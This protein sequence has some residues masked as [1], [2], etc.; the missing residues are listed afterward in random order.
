M[1]AAL[2]GGLTFVATAGFAM[3]F[4][5]NWAAVTGHA[6]SLFVSTV[7]PDQ[8]LLLVQLFI[9]VA[10]LSALTLAAEVAERMRAQRALQVSEAARLEADLE[11]LHTTATE[12]RRIAS[13]VHDIVGHAL[14]VVLLQAGGAR[15]IV[16]DHPQRA[17]EL[18][19]SIESTGRD[20][21]RDL[22][23]ALG[24][25]DGS[26]DAALGRGLADLEE[27]VGSVRDAGVAIAFTME[28]EPRS[29]PR[30]ID[31]SAFRIVQEALTNVVKHSGARSAQVS[32]L[33]APKT[34]RIEVTDGGNTVNV[35]GRG[36]VV[37][38]N[39]QARGLVGMRERVAVLGG[40]L[41]AGEEPHGGYAVR[42]WIPTER[43]SP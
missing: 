43:A 5:I 32:I 3:A 20:A 40:R 9:A 14:N 2:R 15:R 22:D 8:A 36:S 26:S 38:R 37:G 31:W 19:E 4:V 33:Y 28:G 7:E 1:W 12:R 29:L 17:R 24:L 23:A 21:F 6:G 41:E 25:V 27:M 18:M 11:V 34:L 13:E 39:G 35:N 16:A 42:A 30:L 10:L